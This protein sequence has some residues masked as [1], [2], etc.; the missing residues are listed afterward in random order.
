METGYSKEEVYG[1][2]LRNAGEM[3]GLHTSE[4]EGLDPLVRL[5]L[6]AMAKEVEKLG[7]DL[8]SSDTRI[9]RRIAQYLLPDAKLYAQ[10]AHG[11]ARLEPAGPQEITRYDELGY[12]KQWKNKDN[13]NRLESVELG[14]T[15][16]GTYRTDGMQVVCRAQ[17]SELHGIERLRTPVL[18]QLGASLSTGEVYLGMLGCTDEARSLSLYF[19]WLSDP[20]RDSHFR[21]LHKITAFNMRNEGLQVARGLRSDDPVLDLRTTTNAIAGLEERTRIYYD[22]RFLRVSF[23]AA[24]PTGV[25]PV[26]EQAVAKTNLAQLGE[27][28]WLRLVFPSEFDARHVR[29]AVIL[30][31]CVPVVNRKLQK[32][33]YRL[34]KEFNIKRLEIDGFFQGIEK[35]EA[36]SGQKYAEVPSLDMV[37]VSPGTYAMRQGTA[38]RFD[39]RD[40][41][42]FMNH[43]L[44]LL[45]E[46]RRSF[47][48]MDAS[49]TLSDLRSIEQ[50]LEKL[51]KRMRGPEGGTGQRYIMIKPFSGSENAHVF[52][53]T[54][55]GE[56][57]NNLPAGTLLKCKHSGLAAAGHVA[58]VST[59]EGARNEL[60]PKE[61]VQLYKSMVLSRGVLITRQDIIEH[62]KYVGSS[63]LESVTVEEGVMVAPDHG[64][65]LIRCLE[66]RLRFLPGR[67]DPENVERVRRRITADLAASAGSSLPIRVN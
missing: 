53:W 52:Y 2:L 4:L 27:L 23:P 3:W 56:M 24:L 41:L 13:L 46:E 15:S 29:D 49:S 45:K 6:G 58:L 26:I 39:Q 43:L 17:G 31:N 36:S 20:M 30:D 65:G 11:V 1:R 25:P 38:G 5:L 12:E 60:T 7:N 33:V 32:T 47:A 55:D 67:G 19:D 40:G 42:E 51:G 18:A 10:P 48:A 14:F 9:F 59:T 44:D 21:S 34:H 62:C 66:V 8:H 61:T 28:R 63:D 64:S 57:A 37:D 22:E 35:A 54:T 50:V 16:V